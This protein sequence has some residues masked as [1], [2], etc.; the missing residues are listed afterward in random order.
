MLIVLIIIRCYH[1]VKF[2]KQEGQHS[3][4]LENVGMFSCKLNLPQLHIK[5]TPL[6][7]AV[8]LGPNSPAVVSD[9]FFS[10]I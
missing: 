8:G 9:N 3:H 4:I 10:D 1:G 2:I 6:S 7:F 5:P